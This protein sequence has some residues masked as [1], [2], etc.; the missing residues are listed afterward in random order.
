VNERVW[1]IG[2]M[3]LTEE[4]TKIPIPVLVCPPQMQH[5]LTWG[6]I[7]T[8]V[9]RPPCSHIPVFILSQNIEHSFL[10]IPYTINTCKR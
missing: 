1:S 8:S 10:N 9:P 7:R 2:G 4:K 3:I 5:R 6:H